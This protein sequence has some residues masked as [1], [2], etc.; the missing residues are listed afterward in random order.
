MNIYNI[1]NII[2]GSLG[3]CVLIFGAL[4]GMGM[5]GNVPPTKPV[6]LFLLGGIIVLWAFVSSRRHR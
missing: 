1:V 6:V 4:V 3:V 2:C 5:I